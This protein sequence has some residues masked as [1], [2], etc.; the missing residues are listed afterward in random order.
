M[1]Q[2]ILLWVGLCLV[3]LA[4]MAQP[5]MQGWRYRTPITLDNTTN[6]SPLVDHQVKL[7]LATDVLIGAGE[8]KADG[9]DIRFTNAAGVAL[10]HW[11]VNNTLNTPNTEIWVNVDNMPPGSTIDIFLFYGNTAANSTMD[12]DATFLHYDNFDGTALDFGKWTFCG[13]FIPVVSNGEVTFSS[14]SGVND[15]MIRSAQSFSAPITVEMKV[16]SANNGI[17]I[18]GQVDAADN[19]Y[20]M[21]FENAASVDAMR[22]VSFNSPTSSNCLDLSNQSPINSVNAGSLQ[23]LWS[24]S[25]SQASEQLFS[26]P[27]GNETRSDN[28]DAAAF[29]NPLQVVIGS[30]GNTGSISVDYAYTRKYSPVVPGFAFGTRTE[31]VDAVQTSTNAPIC[32]G[33]T[34]RLFG[35]AFAGAIY[36][37]VGPNSFT[38]SDQN[39][40]LPNS[41]FGQVG[42]YVLT[43]SA[44]T[45]CSAVL[46]S[47]QVELDSVPVAGT[48]LGDATLCEGQNS[49]QLQLTGTTGNITYWESAMSPGGPWN[50]ITNTSD[51]LDYLDLI[52]TQYFRSIVEFGACGLDTSNTAVLTVDEPTLG[53]NIIGSTNACFGFHTGTLSL[54]N[55]RGNIL[56]WQ[57]STDAGATWGD[58]ATTNNQI[59]YQNL[60][61]T[62][63]YRVMVQNGVCDTTVSD[64]A[65]I[66]IQPLPIVDFGATSACLGHP[67]DFTNASTIPNGTIDDYTW[68]F[69]DGSGSTNVD[70]VHVFG[71][72]GTHSILLVAES[73]ESCVDSIRADITVL[74]APTADFGFQDV[75]EGSPVSLANTSTVSPGT[76]VTSVWDYADGSPLDTV[77]NGSH[78]Y[79]QFGAYDIGLVVVTDS[80][81]TDS[82]RQEVRVLQ[83]AV[84]DFEVDS[85]CLEE[86]IHFDNLTSTFE[87]STSYQWSFGNGQTSTVREPSYTYP[88]FGTFEVVLQAT[89]FGQCINSAT[90]TVVIHP[91]PHTDFTFDNVC[92][93]DPVDF[94]NLSTIPFGEVNYNWSFG[95]STTGS[96]TSIS[97][98]YNL[99]GNYFV[100]L[101]ATSGQGCTDDTTLGVEIF[102]VPEANFVLVDVCRDTMA[103]ITN[104]STISSGTNAY[105]WDLGDGSTSTNTD[106]NYTYLLDGDFDIKL[107][108]TSNEGCLDSVTKEITIYAIPE[109]D[110]TFEPV[111]FGIPTELENATTINSGFVASY[112]WNL[113][114]QRFSFDQDVVHLYAAAGTYPVNLL[115]TSNFGCTHDT[116]IQLTVNPFP[117]VDFDFNNEC[118]GNPVQ[119]LNF[120]NIAFGTM[121]YDWQFGNGNTSTQSSPEETYIFH[122]FFPVQLTATS[123]QGCTDSLT[124]LIEIYPLPLLDAG[125]DTNVSFGF[126][127][128]L[129]GISPAAVEVDWSPGLTVADNGA[130]VTEARPLE[131]TTFTLTVTDQFGCSNFDEV[132]IEVINDY[133]LLI[134]NVLT[135]NSDGQNDTWKILN[136]DA[137]AVLHITVVDRWG[138][139]VF[140]TDQYTSGWDGTIN[141]DALPEGSYF[142]LITFDES[143][144][145]YKGAVSILREQE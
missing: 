22:L 76:I 16:N 72:P 57:S 95:D 64:T 51:T 96:G 59:S 133:K 98:F 106:P 108:A 19:G 65:I 85:V 137:F 24:F 18:A 120:S 54:I 110:F 8:M 36:S 134:A 111:C 66:W 32:V 87:D 136:A 40:V 99:P 77:A 123:D 5:C 30:F 61:D 112:Q 93:Y 94:E 63:W 145:V 28:F 141:L 131:N 52:D 12:G 2:K 35:P 60:T 102:P 17:G 144:T 139:T 113:G 126:S 90:D 33:D 114:D 55:Y 4:G 44:P 101:L 82:V 3:H 34:L 53:G 92:L 100:N 49:G 14:S 41:N 13:P 130:L 117:E 27:G 84:I 97:H 9:G 25:W 81:C 116:T 115:S 62:T 69:G 26:W 83:R 39:P 132:A 119:F 11:I 47:V 20:G 23:G 74:P 79:G 78:L 138:K 42:E 10:P 37:W 6:P 91:L 125:P 88:G 104:T 122:G 38:S 43:V 73:D 129:A 75:C 142:Y 107:V 89:T 48:L 21:A 121:V 45:G 29:S 80:G 50:T 58:I 67:T 86:I 140:E 1:T 7:T 105:A 31:L 143:D 109:T 124:K 135:P 68:D 70:P 103:G 127:T 46:D 71:T 15:Q 56:R 118:A 128:T